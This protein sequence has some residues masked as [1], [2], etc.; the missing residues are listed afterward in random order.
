MCRRRRKFAKH[1]YTSFSNPIFFANNVYFNETRL[2][3]K[4]RN[5]ARHDY[6][7]A[8]LGTGR[9]SF[10]KNASRY[11]VYVNAG[12]RSAKSKSRFAGRKPKTKIV[13]CTRGVVRVRAN[14]SC[15]LSSII[16]RTRGDTIR[17]STSRI[18]ATRVRYVYTAV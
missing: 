8:A 6:L 14:V 5:R 12:C 7:R 13:Y 2:L 9:V 4:H 3:R 10:R 17:S 15:E 16:T 18:R 11:T 1:E